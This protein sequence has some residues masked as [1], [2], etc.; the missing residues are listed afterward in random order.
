MFDFMSVLSA[1]FEAGVVGVIAY[2]I[3]LYCSSKTYVH[4]GW[5]FGALVIAIAVCLLPQL[6]EL[7]QGS[8]PHD[9]I[10]VGFSGGG[11]RPDPANDLHAVVWSKIIGCALGF[12]V[13]RWLAYKILDI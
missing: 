9:I 11:L 2:S 3:Y 13:A 12:F 5:F 1:L 8:N 7:I 6:F 4:T 10:S